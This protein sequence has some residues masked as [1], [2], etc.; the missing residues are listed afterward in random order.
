MR[1]DWLPLGDSLTRPGARYYT[2][3]E[4]CSC[5][6]WEYRGSRPGKYHNKPCKHMASLRQA[7]QLLGRNAAKWATAER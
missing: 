2:S 3:T 7:L 5:K 1:D 6:D 4:A